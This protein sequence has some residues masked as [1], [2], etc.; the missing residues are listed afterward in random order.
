MSQKNYIEAPVVTILGH[1]DHGKTSLLDYIRSSHVAKGEAG[2]ITQHISAY[3]IEHQNYPLTFIDTP[4]HAAFHAMRRRGGSIANIAI[5]I[6][7]ADDGVMPQTKESLGYIKELKLPFIVAINKTD[8]PGIDINKTKTQLAE[9]GVYVEGFG[10]NTPVVEISA[11]TG[12]NINSLLETLILLVQLEE[13]K[14][15]RNLPPQATVIEANIDPHKGPIATLLVSQGVFKKQDKIYL[16]KNEVGKVRALFDFKNTPLEKALPATPFEIL[17]LSSVPKVGQLLTTNPSD[18][19]EELIS[20]LDSEENQDNQINI[21][22]KADV[23]G[24]LEAIITSLPKGINCVASG[25][26]FVNETDIETAILNKAEII[27]FNVKTSSPISR[28]AENEKIKI[29]PFKIIYKLLEYLQA[30]VDKKEAK[31]KKEKPVATLKVLKIFNINKTQILGC[32]IT[33]GS[34]NKQELLESSRI[35]SLKQGQSDINQAETGE[36][37]GVVVSPPLDASEGDT[38]QSFQ[39]I[40]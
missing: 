21:M 37:V 30:K 40:L 23:A 29:S 7:A 6:V 22:V 10:G 1:V 33:K 32:K 39:K 20:K 25:T 9:E 4:G 2:G 12:K 11:Q 24:T 14:D 13:L 34:L 35:V 5:L 8:L 31:E 17:G 26:G 16:G 36:E 15:T 18:G 3:Q 19:E 28:L 27:S 38:L